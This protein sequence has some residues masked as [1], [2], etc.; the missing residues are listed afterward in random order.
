MNEAPVATGDSGGASAPG[1]CR[2]RRR[3]RPLSPGG[4]RPGDMLAA[5]FVSGIAFLL[6][7]ALT[8]AL[9]ALGLVDWWG[10]WLALHFLLLGGVSQLVLGAA[11]FFSTAYLATDPPGRPM[12]RAQLAVWVSGTLLVAASVPAGVPALADVGVALIVTGLAL[13]WIALRRLERGSLQTARWAIRW[14]YACAAFL[15]AGAILGMLLARHTTWSHGSLLGAHLALNLGG[16]LGTAIV[17]TLHTFYPSLTHSRLAHERLQGPTFVAWCAGVAILSAGAAFDAPMLVAGGWLALTAGALMLA[18]N[19]V[20][21]ARA[22]E[23]PLGLPARL[24]GA[25]Q[26]F[27]VAGLALALAMLVSEGA[28]ATPAG[29]WRAALAVLLVGGWIGMTVAGSLLHLLTVLHR[30][31]NLGA[32]MPQP[33]ARRDIALTASLSTA[34]AALA[35]SYAPGAQQLRSVAAVAA[36]IL[37][38][39]VA[40]RI[41]ALAAEA[42]WRI[43]QTSPLNHYMKWC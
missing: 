37:I 36:L 17:G 33:R 2:S 5:F 6:A 15:A 32:R 3:V 19:I 40:A 29:D 11:Q 8:A 39:P 30:V 42:V 24:V 34:L 21:S 35:I 1:A 26:L 28:S 41:L 22:A 27:L 31:R 38:A 10:R 18:A 13:F 7:G 25:A 12:V 14:Y 43:A 9:T 4:Q 23:G 16:W 20:A